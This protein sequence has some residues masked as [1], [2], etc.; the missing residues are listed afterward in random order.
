MSKR[1]GD[2]VLL[3]EL[4]DLIG[5]DAA[6]WYL[7]LALARPDDRARHR[8]GAR[9]ERQEPGLL[10]AVRACPDRRDRARRG[11]ARGRGGARCDAASRAVRGRAGARDRRVPARR[12]PRLPTCARPTGSRRT[13]TTSPRRSTSSTATAACSTTP[14]PRARGAG[15]RS[16]AP[17]AACWRARSTCSASTRRRRCERGHADRRRRDRRRRR[18]VDGDARRALARQAGR[19][20]RGPPPRRHLRQRR[21]HPHE[22]ARAGG[23]GRRDDPP[24]DALRGRGRGLPRRLPRGDVA[25]ARDR[26]DEPFLLRARGRGRSGHDLGE[27]DRALHVADAARVGRRSGRGRSHHRRLGHRG[28][29]AAGSRPPGGGHRLDRHPRARLAARSARDRRRRV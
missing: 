22:G 29:V 20:V 12:R 18:G 6:R 13:R 27:R 2:V 11:R 24:R 16:S 28:M 4:M 10:R 1:R 8:P 14:M 26:A 19:A 3:D 15:S 25:R 17:R 21:M 7:D 9:A 5:I 23:R